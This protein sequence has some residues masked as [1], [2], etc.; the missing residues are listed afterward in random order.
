MRQKQAEL[1]IAAATA[2]WIQDGQGHT[3]D[4]RYLHEHSDMRDTSEITTKTEGQNH[5][6][7]RDSGAL[8]PE[9]LSPEDDMESVHNI[10]YD[11]ALVAG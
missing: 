2:A 3:A 7:L 5:I 6:F 4:H 1:E 11:A 8:P 9:I 10:N